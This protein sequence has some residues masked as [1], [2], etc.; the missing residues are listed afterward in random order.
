M[1]PD[2]S[3]VYLNDLDRFSVLG[4]YYSV[5]VLLN[6]PQKQARNLMIQMIYMI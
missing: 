2:G 1:F 5:Q 4:L 6:L 3:D